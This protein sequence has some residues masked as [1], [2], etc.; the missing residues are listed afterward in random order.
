MKYVVWQA[1][2][3]VMVAGYAGCGKTTTTAV[4]LASLQGWV[5]DIV[6]ILL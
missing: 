6:H 3:P 1:G 4:A 5:S 2:K